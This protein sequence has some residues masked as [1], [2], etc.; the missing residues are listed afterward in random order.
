MD[1]K[2]AN[3]EKARAARKKQALE[4][5]KKKR[6]RKPPS[7]AQLAALKAG[8]EK[9]C[10]SEKKEKEKS[11]EDILI[12]ITR[13]ITDKDLEDYLKSFEKKQDTKAGAKKKQDTKAG[14]KP[15]TAKQLAAAEK[16]KADHQKRVADLNAARK[17]A[18]EQEEYFRG[19]GLI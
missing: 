2:L 3:L 6:A 4:K 13:N 15:K 11:I 14:A 5:E 18:K 9:L 1:Q 16:R 17:K 8:R 7:A 19:L 10:R 12:E